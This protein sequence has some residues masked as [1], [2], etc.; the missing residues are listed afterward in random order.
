MAIDNPID[1]FEQ[2]YMQEEPTL[3]NKLG[4]RLRG[5]GC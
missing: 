1:A 4:F 3:P 5:Y 2:Q